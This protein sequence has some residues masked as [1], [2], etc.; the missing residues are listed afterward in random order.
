MPGSDDWKKHLPLSEATFYILASLV[1]PMH[2]YAVMQ[3]VE[4]ASRGEVKIGPGTLYGVFSTLEKDG[5]ITKVREEDRRK[6]YTL[7]AKGK[8]VLAAQIERIALMAKFA[9]E[10]NSR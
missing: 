5:L 4:A 3:K 8:K 9:A 6:F 1:E 7:T 10:A 2:G